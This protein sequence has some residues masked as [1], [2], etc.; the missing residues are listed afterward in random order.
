[1]MVEFMADYGP[2]SLDYCSTLCIKGVILKKTTPTNISNSKAFPNA[3]WYSLTQAS[4][5]VVLHCGSDFT[6]LY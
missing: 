4:I 3:W 5:S 2:S 1:M 6:L